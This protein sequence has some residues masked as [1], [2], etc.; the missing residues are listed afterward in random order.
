[1]ERNSAHYS[2]VETLRDGRQLTVRALRPEDQDN[3]LAAVDRTT[4]E[5]L[6]RRFF[7]AKR[8]FTEAERSFYLNV[9]F[10]KHVAIVAIVDENGKS[11]LV[12]GAR[13]VIE[14]AHKA[15]V[16]FMIVDQYQH[17]GIGSALMRHI[18]TIAQNAGLQ[19]LF[20]QVLPANTAMLK[21]FERTNLPVSIKR[22]TDVMNVTLNLRPQSA[23]LDESLH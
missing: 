1:M 4:S 11:T 8:Y 20:A 12:G 23:P 17:L 16:A 13:F 7:G 22:E 5:S 2:A 10:I 14:K 15:E 19:E 6:R 21:V 3:Y 18:I 9:D